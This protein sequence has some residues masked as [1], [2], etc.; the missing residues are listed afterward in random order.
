[1]T[2]DLHILFLAVL[3]LANYGQNINTGLF[4]IVFISMTIYLIALPCDHVAHDMLH[5][6]CPASIVVR[7]STQNVK[8]AF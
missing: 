7:S 6:I 2:T 1:M 3:W 4:Y 8:I 5:K